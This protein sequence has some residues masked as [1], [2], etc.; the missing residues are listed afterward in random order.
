MRA[1]Y[2][3]QGQ[4]A[5]ESVPLEL[6]SGRRRR[7]R[8]R[9]PAVTAAGDGVGIVAWGEDGHIYTRRVWGTSPSIVS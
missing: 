7:H 1:A 2:Y 3:D 6:S 8:N 4:W 9:A 5:L